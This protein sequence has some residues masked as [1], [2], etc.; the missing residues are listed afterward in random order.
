LMVR[1][2]ELALVETN[3]KLDAIGRSLHGEIGGLQ[4]RGRQRVRVSC[5][6]IR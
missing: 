4:A 1:T 6:S 2:V 3:E 5:P